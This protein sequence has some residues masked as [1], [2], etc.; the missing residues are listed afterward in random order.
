MRP[1]AACEMYC[2]RSD[3]LTGPT[4]LNFTLF[5][6]SRDTV[7]TNPK[8]LRVRMRCDSTSNGALLGPMYTLLTFVPPELATSSVS[9]QFTVFAAEAHAGGVVAMA[10]PHGS[11]PTGMPLAL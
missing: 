4:A 6:P 1:V 3:Q 8:M 5:K 11:E 7:T 2:G 10:M 9:W